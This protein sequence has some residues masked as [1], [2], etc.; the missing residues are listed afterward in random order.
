M[1]KDSDLDF[2][3]DDNGSD[4][5]QNE[6]NDKQHEEDDSGSESSFMSSSTYASSASPTP[7]HTPSNSKIKQPRSPSPVNQTINN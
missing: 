3:V 6:S 1:I 7:I 5:D 2:L 4:N